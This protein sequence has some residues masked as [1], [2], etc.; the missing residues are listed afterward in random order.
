MTADAAGVTSSMWLELGAAPFR[1]EF[2]V[3]GGVRTRVLVAGSGPGLILLHGTGGH[4]EAYQKNVVPLSQHFT[5]IVPDMIGHG[6]TDRPDLDYT[7][8]DYADHAFGLLDHYGFEQAF[9]SGESIGGCVAVWMA[10]RSPR[11]VRALV[12]NTGILER[13]DAAGL[14]QLEDLEVRTQRLAEGLS[15]EAV[16]RRM[17][18]LVYD[19]SI[20]TDEM[21]A[22]RR[23][24]YSQPGMVADVQKIMHAVI[25][26][27]RGPYAGGDY[28]QKDRLPEVS[29]PTQVLWSDHNPGKPYA[30]VKP[31]IELIPNVETHVIKNAAHWPQYEQPEHVNTL[32]IE[33]L[34]GVDG[35]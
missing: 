20:M 7:L 9:V 8:D 28:I 13:P 16:R 5:V 1:V 6:Y 2:P 3:I 12:L 22:V 21:I 4:L 35:R 15:L 32:M 17:E 23:A 19:P 18:W 33:F 26:M 31:A 29:C 25:E 34:L 10:L 30:R 27:N 14:K 24:I 11:R